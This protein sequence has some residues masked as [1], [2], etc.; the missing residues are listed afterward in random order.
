MLFLKFVFSERI[1]KCMLN[2]ARF[3]LVIGIFYSK[4]YNIHI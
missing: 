4:F 2:L 1:L 3:C